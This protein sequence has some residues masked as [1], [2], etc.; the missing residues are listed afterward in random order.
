[1][2]I[3]KVHREGLNRA[4]SSAN[5]FHDETVGIGL[6]IIKI[7]HD[8]LP[9]IAPVV[10]CCYRYR[11]SNV[12]LRGVQ[13]GEDVANTTPDV[14]VKRALRPEPHYSTELDWHLG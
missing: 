10:R 4:R 8:H 13:P 5:A 3:L 11:G 7:P 14:G 1:M 9:V 12:G 6:D 2:Q